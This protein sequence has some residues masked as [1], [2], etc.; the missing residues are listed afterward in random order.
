MALYYI[1]NNWHAQPE[2]IRLVANTVLVRRSFHSLLLIF[3][4]S[5][6]PKTVSPNTARAA[7]FGQVAYVLSFFAL[8]TIFMEIYL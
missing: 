6:T 3:L 8:V 7:V 4:L 1:T 5:N 2:V